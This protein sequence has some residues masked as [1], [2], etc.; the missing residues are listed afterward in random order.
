MIL[1][2][3]FTIAKGVKLLLGVVGKIVVAAEAA[4]APVTARGRRVAAARW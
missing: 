2:S 3:F 4:D 1:S